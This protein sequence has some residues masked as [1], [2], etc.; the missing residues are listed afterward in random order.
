MTDSNCWGFSCVRILAI[1][2]F[3]FSWHQIFSRILGQ[4]ENSPVRRPVIIFT[5]VYD[6]CITKQPAQCQIAAKVWASWWAVFFFVSFWCFNQVNVIY[7]FYTQFCAG[8]W[9]GSQGLKNHDPLQKTKI[10]WRKQTC[11]KNTSGSKMCKACLTTQCCWSTEKEQLPLMGNQGWIQAEETFSW[12][13]KARQ[14]KE[15]AG[16]KC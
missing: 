1:F 9:T 10:H 8:Q 5:L 11:N 6:V 16:R 14:V 12:P 15:S 13:W 3:F 7:L 2:A 4:Q